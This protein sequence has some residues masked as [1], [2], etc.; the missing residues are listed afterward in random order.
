MPLGLE[1]AAPPRDLP[2][3]G[4]D[5]GALGRELA[6]SPKDLPPLGPDMGSLGRELAAPCKDLPPLGTVPE[7]EDELKDSRN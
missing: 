3:L 4:P 7:V 2:P 5:I 1:L 6:P